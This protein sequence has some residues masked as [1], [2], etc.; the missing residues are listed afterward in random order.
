MIIV[1]GGIKGGSG[2]TTICTNLVVERS[3]IRKV[4]M[5]DADGQH[6]ASDWLDIRENEQVPIN[7][8]SVQ[9]RGKYVH[10]KL[11]SLKKD[12]EE[13]FVDT[14]G[15]D[16][17]SQRSAL[18]VADIFIAPFQ[19]RSLDLWTLPILKEMVDELSL[20][21]PKLRT[22]IV[23]NKADPKGQDNNVS[24]KIIKGF[25]SIELFPSFI[26][27]RKSFCKAS[28]DGLGIKELKRQDKKAS[29]E[30]NDFC[31]YVFDMKKT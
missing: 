23:V 16:T 9:L 26:K 11:L 27:Q 29:S 7:W 28:D 2:K 6:S 20:L 22:I 31:S 8:T 5:V 14:G 13:I 19:P 17:D 30:F 24:I 1:V 18:T 12:Y 15:S 3:S 25:D 21:N 10:T 4:L